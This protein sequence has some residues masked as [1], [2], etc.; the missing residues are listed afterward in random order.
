MGRDLK[1]DSQE[2]CLVIKGKFECESMGLTKY[3]EAFS[4]FFEIIR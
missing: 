2:E 1:T 4:K 3:Y